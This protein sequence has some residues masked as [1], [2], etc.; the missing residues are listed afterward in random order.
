MI[1]EPSLIACFVADEK[2]VAE[3]GNGSDDPAI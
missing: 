3:S 2:H 1:S